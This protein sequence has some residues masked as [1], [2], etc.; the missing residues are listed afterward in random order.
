MAETIFTCDCGMILKVYGDNL[1]GHQIVCPSCGSTVVVP[2]VSMPVP[3]PT[4]VV[5]DGSAALAPAS[6]IL[7]RFGLL[8]LG[9]I[10]ILTLGLAKFVLMPIL[11]PP[12]AGARNEPE[13]KVTPSGT[14]AR[15]TRTTLPDD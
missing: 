2:T 1:I 13:T 6:S 5:P 3:E 7:Q 11:A 12:G 15:P 14:E 4:S 10:T 8:Y 9:G